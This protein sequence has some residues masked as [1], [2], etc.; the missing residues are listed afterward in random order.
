LP[1][2]KWAFVLPTAVPGPARWDGRVITAGEI[3]VCP[4]QTESYTFDP[5]GLQFAM[6]SA[7][8]ETAL[9][10]MGSEER[11]LL[12]SS[13]SQIVRPTSRNL[14]HL[15]RQLLELK[16]AAEMRLDAST[17]FDLLKVQND[18]CR[19]LGDCLQSVVTSYNTSI[20]SRSR[21]EIVR[22]AEQ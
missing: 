11:G 16:S 4:P 3:I 18:V 13:G 5:A 14:R 22:R 6:I 17:S 20:V 19:A 10:L 12:T 15:R 7:P 9:A 8:T 21:S 1:V 2:D